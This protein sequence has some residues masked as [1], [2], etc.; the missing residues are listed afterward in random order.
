[1]VGEG[2]G[3]QKGGSEG[4]NEGGGRRGRGGEDEPEGGNIHGMGQAMRYYLANSLPRQ[5]N[6][7]LELAMSQKHQVVTTV[8]S[9]INQ[10]V[11]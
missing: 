10:T 3:N 6:T 11:V 8:R 9:F 5:R 7:V 2:R 4:E 1:M